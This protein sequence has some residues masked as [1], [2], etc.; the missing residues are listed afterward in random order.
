MIRVADEFATVKEIISSGASIAR[1][2]DGEL[3]LCLGIKQMCQPFSP[4]IQNALRRILLEEVPGLLVGIPRIY[5][6]D[7]YPIQGSQKKGFWRR[8]QSA[9]H[10]GLYD[11]ERQYYSAFIT[12]PDSAGEIDCDEYWGMIRDIW[13]GR[14]VVLLQGFD[15]EFEKDSR[16]FSQ[17]SRLSIVYG[18]RHN[19]YRHLKRLKKVLLEYPQTA[20][21]I[22]SLGPTATVLAYELAQEGRQ[23][24][25]LGHLGMFFA[26][27]HPKSTECT[28]EYYD[29]DKN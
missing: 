3:K 28:G 20:L 1:Y 14:E 11:S 8:Y 12:R 15:R 23:T 17:A 6:P 2:G 4:E 29:T 5:D 21:L 24:L 13:S 7:S 26:R 19:A 10:M 22:L 27:H 9:G 25:D 18:P 16:L